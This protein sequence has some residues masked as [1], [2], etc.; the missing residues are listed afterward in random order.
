MDICLEFQELTWLARGRVEVGA[1]IV[2]VLIERNLAAINSCTIF[3]DSSGDEFLTCSAAGERLRV[4]GRKGLVVGSV[5]GCYRGP[6]HQ[7]DQQTVC[8]YCHD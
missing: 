4:D 8:S 2:E 6:E 5:P 3:C 1:S 7:R